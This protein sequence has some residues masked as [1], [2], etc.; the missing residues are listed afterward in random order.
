MATILRRRQVE[1]ET[2]NSRSGI[3]EQIEAG[4]FTTS[5]KIGARAV[6]WPA[7]EVQAIAAARIA[8]LDDGEI[9]ELVQQLH[10]R[11][12]ERFAALVGAE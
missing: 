2:G 8:G 1:A 3:Y 12:A 10:A 11:R 5:V 9:R 7:D 6:G 4:L